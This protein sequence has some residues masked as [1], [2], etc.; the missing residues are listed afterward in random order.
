MK[1][2][3]PIFIGV[4]I[5]LILL[6]IVFFFVGTGTSKNAGISI[7]TTPISTVFIDGV[8]VGK[9]PYIEERKA[10]EI[11][12]KLVPVAQ[13]K[14]MSP[15]ETKVTLNPKIETVIKRD[16]GET[17]ELSQGEIISFEKAGGKETAL[18]VVSLPDNS[19]IFIDGVQKGFAPLKTT[20]LIAGEH[21][22]TVKAPGYFE[23]TVTI[24]TYSGYKLTAVIKLAPSSQTPTP[25]PTPEEQPTQTL[26][27][28]LDTPTGFLRVRLTPSA[29]GELVGEA[30][31]G[32]KFRY[33]ETDTVTGWFK[34]EFAQGKDGWVSNKYS[35]KIEGILPTPTSPTI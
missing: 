26:V 21:Q 3:K 22:L 5:T 28:I 24:Q 9:T 1:N 30:T 13:A 33:L 35:K 31:P 20:S 15:F 6:S 17:D 25:T 4:G 10:G 16:F 14:I 12:V 34:I 23:R 8:E 32:E 11:L 29:S 18:A 19:Q 2:L 27:E 7:E